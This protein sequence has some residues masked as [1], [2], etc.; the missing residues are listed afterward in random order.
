MVDA[1]K[2]N[3]AVSRRKTCEFLIRRFGQRRWEQLV[4][5]ARVYQERSLAL[6]DVCLRRNAQRAC[7]T[8]YG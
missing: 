3:A 2:M 5:L 6:L 7:E 1:L 8:V 4:K